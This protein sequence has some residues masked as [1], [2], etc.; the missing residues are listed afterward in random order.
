MYYSSELECFV[1]YEL[2]ND[3]LFINSILSK[4]YIPIISILERIHED[5]KD[6]ILGFTPMKSEHHIFDYKV[7]DGA[8]ALKISIEL[9][10][11]FSKS[12][13]CKW[14]IN[15]NKDYWS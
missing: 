7:F 1:C 2:D 13:I 11:S 10:P 5:Y 9:Y 6:I 4:N 3:T 12:T 8:D 14:S 15:Q